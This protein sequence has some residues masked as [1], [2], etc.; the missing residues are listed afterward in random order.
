MAAS[1][2]ASNP[3]AHRQK[4]FEYSHKWQNG[5]SLVAAND[6]VAPRREIFARTCWIHHLVKLY[7]LG[8]GKS[9]HSLSLRLL[10]AEYLTFGPLIK[11]NNSKTQS[12][13]T[14]VREV[15]I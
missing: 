10:C 2:P 15:Q 7:L 1:P 8:A 4:F 6:P 5:R 13:W 14:S 12:C 3:A 9:R 11:L